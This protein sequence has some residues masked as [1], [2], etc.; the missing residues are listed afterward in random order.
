MSYII[1]K[2]TLF[3]GHQKL[4]DELILSRLVG[5]PV[6]SHRMDDDQG[7]I[8]VHEDLRYNGNKTGS[9]G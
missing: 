8:V 9:L 2:R 7:L 4:Q 6:E 3:D 1:S 5:F